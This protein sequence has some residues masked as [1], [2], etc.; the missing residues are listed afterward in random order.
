MN[1]KMCLK[2]SSE[3]ICLKCFLRY[4][5]ELIVLNEKH[6]NLAFVLFY[7]FFLFI[8]S[9]CIREYISIAVHKLY[10]NACIA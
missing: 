6:L 8:E 5:S 3:V 2:R 7:L 1:V 4:L 9:R 10:L